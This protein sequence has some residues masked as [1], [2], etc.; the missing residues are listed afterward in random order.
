MFKEYKRVV[1]PGGQIIILTKWFD[2]EIGQEDGSIKK[3]RKQYGNGTPSLLPHASKS[4]SKYW[5][6]QNYET[7]VTQNKKKRR[8][9]TMRWIRRRKELEE[10][11]KEEECEVMR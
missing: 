6:S 7:I 10:G 3:K 4:F 2:D 8:Y 11:E 9:L 1:R 5:I